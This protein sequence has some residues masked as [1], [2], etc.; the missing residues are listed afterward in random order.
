MK[1]FIIVV[2]LLA[3][4]SL[5]VADAADTCQ[6]KPVAGYSSTDGVVLSDAGHIITFVAECPSNGLLDILFLVSFFSN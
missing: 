2:S 6:A 5:A 1:S 4:W 3:G